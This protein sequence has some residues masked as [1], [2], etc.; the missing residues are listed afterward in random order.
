MLL[1]K[2]GKIHTMT[3]EIYVNDCILINNGKIEKI[4]KKIDV[5]DE[6]LQVIDAKGGWVMQDLLMLIVT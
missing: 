2:N 3:G 4:A 5:S 6:N 1:I